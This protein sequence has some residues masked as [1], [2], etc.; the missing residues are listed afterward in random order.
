M[1]DLRYNQ[2]RKFITPDD[3]QAYAALY[4]PGL[5]YHTLEVNQDS[6]TLEKPLMGDREALKDYNH[7]KAPEDYLSLAVAVFGLDRYDPR[8]KEWERASKPWGFGS[9]R[10]L[11]RAGIMKRNTHIRNISND[12][13][14]SILNR[15]CI[16]AIEADDLEA[17]G[18]WLSQRV[19]DPTGAELE[20]DQ[21]KQAETY[22]RERA[23]MIEALRWSMSCL[24]L[25][26]LKALEMI[27]RS[28]RYD[29]EA[30]YHP[31]DDP[32]ELLPWEP[33]E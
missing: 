1:D 11:D 3:P 21:V 20:S 16:K 4:V 22:R 25:D 33:W 18:I 32:P 8:R 29:P 14:V 31:W 5:I 23:A 6:Y 30:D 2:I 24:N 7:G 17:F 26:Q 19:T 27:V 13:A 10:A 28:M 9:L 12:R 15:I